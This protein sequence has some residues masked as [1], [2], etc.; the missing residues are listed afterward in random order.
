[1][2][3]YYWLAAHGINPI[4]DVKT[5]TVPPPQMVANMRIGNMDGYCV[6]EPWN[7]R[8]IFDKVGF[9]VATS[10]DIWVDHRKRCWHD[11][12]IRAEEPQHRTRHADGGTG[13]L[14]LYRCHRNRPAVAK[15]I[16]SKSYVNA[17]EEV[18]EG[19]FLGH[20]EQRHRQ[21]MG[22]PELHEVLQ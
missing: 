9:S 8:A 15:L 7:A 2:W 5:I 19:R 17:P 6:G 20:Y 4:K 18:I 1:M 10:Q 22:R 21:E 14:P 3:L 12:R 13:G 16:A 11:S